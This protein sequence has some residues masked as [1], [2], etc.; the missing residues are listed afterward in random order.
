M[1][2]QYKII[3]LVTIV[4][5]LNYYKWVILATV[6]NGIPIF[7][8]DVC[9]AGLIRNYVNRGGNPH[10]YLYNIFAKPVSNSYSFLACAVQNDDKEIVS[11]LINQG[12]SV[13]QK[14]QEGDTPLHFVKSIAMAKFLLDKGANINAQGEYRYSPLHLVK[15]P[16]LAKYL[17]ERGADVNAKDLGDT[18]P[19][20][21]KYFKAQ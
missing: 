13:N 7:S 14:D 6:L 4:F 11:K 9:D 17:I 19:E 10:I 5:A 16:D 3:N 15:S 20:W 18:K 8:G 2:S 12:V 1:P 21:S